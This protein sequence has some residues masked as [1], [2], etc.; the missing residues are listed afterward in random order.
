MCW[1]EQL[2]SEKLALFV[3]SLR[4]DR[5]LDFMSEGWADVFLALINVS[6]YCAILGVVF[7]CFFFMYKASLKEIRQI[8]AAS[9]KEIREAYEGAYKKLTK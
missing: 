2:F 9:I 4:N 3:R 5:R 6:P 1:S 8:S 7:C